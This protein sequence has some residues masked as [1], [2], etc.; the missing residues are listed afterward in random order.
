M[1]TSPLIDLGSGVS[2]PQLGFG[3]FQVPPDETK[4]A[5]LAAL[6]A[7]YR[8]IDTATIYGNE[9]GVGQAIAESGIARDEL[10]IT[11]K[12]WNADQGAGTIDA[13]E[14][15]LELLGL[16]AVDLYLIHWPAPSADLYVQTWETMLDISASGRSRSVGVSNFRPQDLRRLADLG[17]TMPAVNQIELHPYLVQDELRKLHADHGIVTEAWSPLAQGAVLDDALISGIAARHEVSG[18]QVV[19]AWHL[20]IGNVV[21]PKSV[22]PSRIAENFASTDV[23]LSVDEVAAITALDRGQRVGP[24]PDDV[25]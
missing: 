9:E 10:F 14:T 18:A 6:E 4:A 24:H 21:I 3:V 8:H 1:S 19:L 11:T 20:A 5:V 22:T 2:I 25:G 12:L 13:F 23:E 16:D 17:L 7:G 15:S